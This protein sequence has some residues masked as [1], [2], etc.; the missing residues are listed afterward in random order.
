MSLTFREKNA[1][2]KELA[3]DIH[4]E[5]D[6]QLLRNHLPGDK[7]LLRSASSS[8]PDLSFDII[9]LIL[10]FESKESII[11]NR[12]AGSAAKTEEKVVEKKQSRTLSEKKKSQKS[13]SIQ[14]LSGPNLKVKTSE[15]LT[16]CIQT[17]STVIAGCAS[18]IKSLT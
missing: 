5:K 11:S 7:L 9:F 16:Q 3:N 14:K 1:I 15:M 12:Q 13:R 2:A 4:I 18:W 17:G 10:D 8:R 6:K